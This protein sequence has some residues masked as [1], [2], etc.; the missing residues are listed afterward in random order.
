MNNRLPDRSTP[1][2]SNRSCTFGI[3]V[4]L[5]SFSGGAFW[6]RALGNPRHI[7]LTN[8]NKSRWS[9][10]IPSKAE[11][12]TPACGRSYPTVSTYVTFWTLDAR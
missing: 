1:R 5:I 6:H 7:K 8:G 11:L 9:R 4:F 2:W 3:G 12:A 10:M